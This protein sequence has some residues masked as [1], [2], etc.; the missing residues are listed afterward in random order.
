MLKTI[1]CEQAKGFFMTAD[2]RG[3]PKTDWTGLEKWS[4]AIHTK[5]R[6]W[7]VECTLLRISRY[8][9]S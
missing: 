4:K 8:P 1:V 3:K 9:K 5:V 7:M 2:F 6:V